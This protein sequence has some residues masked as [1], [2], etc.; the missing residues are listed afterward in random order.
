LSNKR[1]ALYGGHQL[2]SPAHEKTPNNRKVSREEEPIIIPVRGGEEI[3]FTLSQSKR[4]RVIAKVYNRHRGTRLPV[5][6]TLVR[7]W[8][9][10]LEHPVKSLRFDSMEKK[11][12]LDPSDLL[13][14]KVQFYN[15]RQD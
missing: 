7:A 10:I 8:T 11:D 5:A 15:T 1:L 6:H 12:E 14:T 3:R 13:P 2:R 9:E 4:L